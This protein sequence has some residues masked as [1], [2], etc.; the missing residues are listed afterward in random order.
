MVIGDIRSGKFVGK[1]VVQGMNG[2]KGTLSDLR[3]RKR[4]G[5]TFI[6]KKDLSQIY[7]YE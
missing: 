2:N 1:F 3:E 5:K 4:L 6:E 7:L